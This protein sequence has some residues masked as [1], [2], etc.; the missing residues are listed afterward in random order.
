MKLPTLELRVLRKTDVMRSRQLP[1]LALAFHGVERPAKTAVNREMCVRPE[2]LDDV[3][4]VLKRWQYQFVTFGELAAAAGAGDAGGLVALTFDD[5]FSGCARYLPDI[6]EAHRVPATVFVVS[7]WLGR[8]HPDAPWAQIVTADE[9]R[10]LH[11]AGIEIG[12]HAHTHARLDELSY[13]DALRELDVSKQ[14]LESVVGDEVAVAAYPF[15]AATDDT[16]AACRTAGYRA[17][18]RF[19]G[20]GSWLDPFDL[21]RQPVGLG[22]STLALRL[23]RDDRYEGLRRLRLAKR[24]RR[25]HRDVRRR[26]V[27]R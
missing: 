7:G 11:H 13:A 5:G 24:L 23:K 21:P 1:P 6:L 10:A 16:R 26:Q 8:P 12:S 4:R 15:G 9:V 22:T 3:I 19:R 25:M 27:R 20:A 18:C 17:A 14:T 2:A